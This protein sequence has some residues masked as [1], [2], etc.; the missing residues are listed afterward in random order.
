[1]LRL[2]TLFRLLVL[3]ILVFQIS[4]CQR[5]S[6]NACI[7]GFNQEALFEN[8]ADNVILPAFEDFQIKI[9]NL[10]QRATLFAQ[11]PNATNLR[12][13]RED[14]KK[15]W[16]SWQ[17][18]AVF[19]FGYPETVDLRASLNSFPT[20]TDLI[21]QNIEAGTYDLTS[22]ESQ[23]AK[24]FPALDYLLYGL[25]NSDAAI[26]NILSQEN[27]YVYVLNLISDIQ[28]RMEIV[29]EEWIDKEYRST[30]IKNLGTNPGT[31]LDLIV[32]SM[33]RQFDVVKENKIGIPAGL[34][35]MENGQANQV[36]AYYSGFSLELATAAVQAL[37]NTYLGK[38]SLG[39]DDYLI[40]KKIEKEE[41][42]LNTLI[43]EQFEKTINALQAVN[44]PLSVAME[45]R[46]EQVEQ[47]YLELEQLGM[48]LKNDLAGHLCVMH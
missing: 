33:L 1:M 43:E 34:S 45:Q 17:A 9:L 26:V 18:V 7:E 8:M 3:T 30:F 42:L 22:Q 21:I 19:Q 12:A 24:G 10:R 16:L 11:T 40:H 37:E 29:L 35:L 32:Q 20:N 15:A 5:Q 23:T 46:R 2:Q 13:M 47:V 41:V 25:S 6:A 14:L 27:Y 4:S 48:L 31:S 39:L 38:T 36:E 44:G 28:T